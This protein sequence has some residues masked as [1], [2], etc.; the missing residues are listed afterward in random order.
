[1]RYQEDFILALFRTGILLSII[2]PFAIRAAVQFDN[3]R[4]IFP[5]GEREVTIRLMNKGNEPALMQ[6]WVDQGN[7]DTKPSEADAPFLVMPPIFR[8]DPKEAK[9]VR[10]IFA[11]EK[12]AQDR[13]SLYWLNFLEIPSIPKDSD[14]NF[15]QFA[16]R[17]RF[18]LLYRPVGLPGSLS[19]AVK[20]IKWSIS[21]Q[22]EGRYVL[23]G[24]NPTPYHVS[25]KWLELS[26]G[27]KNYVVD[28]GM[29]NPFSQQTYSLGEI[30]ASGENG[31]LR[32]RW[33]SDYG[34][35]PEK[36]II[37]QGN[38]VHNSSP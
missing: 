11:G 31:K 10:I 34:I 18:K 33:M 9:N 38:S 3:T 30:K 1:M 15:I 21:K 37:L 32:Y 8:L 13:E 28:L 17:S 16:L 25:Y 7:P 5:S 35:S 22:K 6:A 2:F 14:A 12:L 19:E 29:I 27:N 24:E 26:Y 20:Q 23:K 36:E 4:V